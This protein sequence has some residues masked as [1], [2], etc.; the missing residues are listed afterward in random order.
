[1]LLIS[2][3]PNFP[4]EVLKGSDSR[5]MAFDVLS[6]CGAVEAEAQQRCMVCKHS[7]F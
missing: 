2:V 4:L 1:M 6:I 5:F 3:E 7:L